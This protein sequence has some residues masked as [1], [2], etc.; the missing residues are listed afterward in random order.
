MMSG[1]LDVLD[2][3]LSQAHPVDDSVAPAVVRQRR[4]VLTATWSRISYAT[5]ALAIDLE[6]LNRHTQCNEDL[7]AII[8]DMPDLLASNWG[9]DAWSF[10]AD[11]LDLT[12][13]DTDLALDLHQE[14]VSSDLGDPNVARSLLVRVKSQQGELIERKHRI[15]TE[16]EQIREI[17]LFQY[18][19]GI[20]S[21]DDWLA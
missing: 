2:G 18:A 1:V 12:A 6:V 15:E 8:D 11:T 5:E 13:A 10:S 20:A 3:V 9:G 21:A 16:I 7:Q 19:N 14:M 4:A 17:L